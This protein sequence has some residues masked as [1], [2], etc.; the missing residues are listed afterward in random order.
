[1]DDPRGYLA[2]GLMMGFLTGVQGGQF[3]GAF[4]GALTFV[5]L[6]KDYGKTERALLLFPSWTVGYYSPGVLTAI[7]A[8]IASFVGGL[9]CITLSVSAMSAIKSGRVADWLARRIKP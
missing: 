7:P 6:A 8:E 3:L 1:M 9:L 2:A 5:V 4:M